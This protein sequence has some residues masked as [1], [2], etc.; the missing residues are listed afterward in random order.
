M[1]NTD[2]FV[3]GEVGAWHFLSTRSKAHLHMI[4]QPFQCVLSIQAPTLP[5]A[6]IVTQ[7]G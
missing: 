6:F 7:H 5:R 3:S 2:R 1:E 4:T